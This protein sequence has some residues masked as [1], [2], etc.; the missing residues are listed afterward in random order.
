M[1]TDVAAPQRPATTEPTTKQE[2]ILD[3]AIA[4]FLAEGYERSSVDQIALEAGVS[5]RTI[6]NHFADKK[7]LFLEVIALQRQRSQIDATLTGDLLN[8]EHPLRD[9]LE[10][11]AKRMFDAFQQPA[12]LEL[13]RLVIAE[14]KHHP[15][16]LDACKEGVPSAI[17]GWLAN[18]IAQLHDRGL[19]D[20]P[21]PR[22]AA[23]NFMGLLAYLL[24][25]RT[26]WG[27]SRLEGEAADAVAAELAEFFLRAY[28]PSRG[29]TK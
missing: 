10:T 29:C 26:T 12:Y 3:A 4:V 5:K 16:L 1:F 7:A 27:T 13:K 18:R 28:L 17:R 24:Q 23:E 6:Y 15:E 9:D 22:Q 25:T 19:L 21:N 20:A 2:T 14:V 11:F 8:G